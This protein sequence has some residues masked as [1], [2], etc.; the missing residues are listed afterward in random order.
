[1]FR[2]LTYCIVG[3]IVTFVR[4]GA[5]YNEDVYVL[6][7]KSIIA[8]IAGMMSTLSLHLFTYLF[9]KIRSKKSEVR[10]KKINKIDYD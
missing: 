6:F 1:M 9:N 10:S 4:L 3:M 8:I 2:D 7:Y 5:M